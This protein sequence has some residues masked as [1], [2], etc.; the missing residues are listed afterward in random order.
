MAEPIPF[1]VRERAEELYIVEGRTLEQTAKT[2]KISEGSVM[3]WSAENGWKDKQREYRRALSD[4]KRNT[5]LLRKKLIQQAMQS[6]D[7]QHVYAVARLEAAAKGRAEEAQAPPEGEPRSIATAQDA[8]DALQEAVESKINRMLAHPEAIKLAA[9]RDMKKVFE[10]IDEMKAKYTDKPE[11]ARR[12]GLS[13]EVA[14]QVK[15]KIL[16]ITVP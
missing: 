14:D 11:E 5:V 2:L 7:P 6:L 12:R 13:D 16:G 4:I 10:L 1:E 3:R 15:Q 8:I 9:I